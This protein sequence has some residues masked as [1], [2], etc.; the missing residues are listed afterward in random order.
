[1]LSTKQFLEDTFLIKWKVPNLIFFKRVLRSLC[2]CMMCHARGLRVSLVCTNNIRQHTSTYVSGLRWGKTPLGE[3]ESYNSLLKRRKRKP[4]REELIQRVI[5]V[6]AKCDCLFQLR[7]ERCTVFR[8][9][10]SVNCAR[11]AILD[12]NL[13]MLYYRTTKTAKLSKIL[14]GLDEIYYIVALT[15]ISE[16]EYSKL[17]RVIV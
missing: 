12:S 15:L 13:N 8:K 16:N 17:F 3:P 9:T 10:K 6:S 7:V 2:H 14:S 5:E 4:K 1:M 11:F